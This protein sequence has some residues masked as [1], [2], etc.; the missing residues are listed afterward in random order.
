M[1]YSFELTDKVRDYE[2][3]MQGVVN[4]SC[5]FSYCENARHEYLLENGVDFAELARQNV[6][7]VVVEANGKFKTPLTS[8]DKYVIR[9][10]MEKEG[11]ARFAFVQDIYRAADDKLAFSARIIGA[12][13]NERGRPFVPEQMQKLIEQLETE[14]S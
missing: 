13:V 11:R 1:S 4:N 2:L 3:D 5:Y 12:A 7:L 6:N 10:R 8:G 14:S 9:M